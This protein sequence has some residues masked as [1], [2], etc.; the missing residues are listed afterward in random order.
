[1]ITSAI[2]LVITCLYFGGSR[3]SSLSSFGDG[4]I[5]AIGFILKKQSL[6]NSLIQAVRDVA[7]VDQFRINE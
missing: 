6:P 4:L 7:S 2:D 1:M 3:V 5:S